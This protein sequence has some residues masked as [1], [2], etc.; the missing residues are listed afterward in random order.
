MHRTLLGIFN[1][2]HIIKIFKH[3]L[4]IIITQT[5]ATAHDLD[6]YEGTTNIC[7]TRDLSRSLVANVPLHAQGKHN[8]QTAAT[9]VLRLAVFC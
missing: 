1:T 9:G 8:R 3:H 6:S 4:H 5:E 7:T 2:P